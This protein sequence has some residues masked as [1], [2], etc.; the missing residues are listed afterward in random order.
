MPRA[1]Y[2]IASLVVLIAVSAF[3]LAALRQHTPLWASAA[4]TGMLGVLLAASIGAFRADEPRRTFWLGFALCGW[5]YGI[6]TFAPGA[7]TTLAPQ[8]LTTQLVEKFAPSE[9]GAYSF[10]YSTPTMPKPSLAPVA[11]P[12]PGMAL[13]STPRPAPPATASASTTT[14]MTNIQTGR[15]VQ[16]NTPQPQQTVAAQGNTLSYV[17][18]LALAPV[19]NAEFVRIGKALSVL[20]VALLGGLF[21]ALCFAPRRSRGEEHEHAPE[22][23]EPA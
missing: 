17:K 14:V 21:A 18:R 23:G 13:S 10:A 7:D 22:G 3:A 15:L 16:V 8:L 20:A 12:T 5:V 1:R 4:F 6:V 2:S 19:P 11:P 9:A